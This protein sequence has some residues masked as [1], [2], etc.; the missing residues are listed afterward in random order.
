MS[1]SDPAPS[2]HVVA[3]SGAGIAD[4]GRQRLLVA[5]KWA[6]QISGTAYIPLPHAE[7]EAELLAV[8]N[9]LFD[10]I[11]A[12]PFDPEPAASIGARLVAMNCIGQPT[13]QRTMDVLG[14]ALLHQPELCGVRA[15][16]DKVVTLLGTF[17]AGYLESVREATLAQQE[18]LNRTMIAIGNDARTGLRAA[19]ARIGAIMD[20][21]PTGIAI[22]DQDGRIRC[23]N[24]V[25]GTLLGHSAGELT[26]LSL[27]DLFPP[28]DATFV[29]DA[30]DRLLDGSLRRLRQRRTMV[31]R[32]GDTVPVTLTGELVRDAGDQERLV[33]VVQDDSELRLLQNQLTR[34]SLH[35]VVTGLP[36]RQFF[37]TRLETALH[38]A[39]KH[40]ATLYHL[41]LDAFAMVTD[42]LGRHVGDQLL[43]AVAERLRTVV[44]G[45][46]AIVARLDSDEFAILV[47]NTATT[48]DA[49]TVVGRI[50]ERLAEPVHV[51]GRTVTVS[52]SMGV[53]HRPR[54]D[55]DAAELLRAS[56]LALR[57]AKRHGRR[58]WE[59]FDPDA[60]QADRHRFELATTMSSAWRAGEVRLEYRPQVSLATGAAVALEPVLRWVHPRFGV[61]PH[62][63]C[64]ELAEQT[65]LMV[66]LGDWLL[67]SACAAALELPLVV[68]LS[69]SQVADPD[70][71]DRVLRIDGLVPSRLSL[72]VPVRALH[73]DSTVPAENLRLLAD[74]GIGVALHGFDGAA[75]DLALLDE[76]PVSGVR[77][78]A[79]VVAA[80]AAS[81][82]SVLDR[83]LVD[84]VG[85]V[86][87]TGGAVAVDGVDS[88]AQV[89][90]WR[91]AGAD[92]A[93]GGQFTTW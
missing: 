33:V 9:Q 19:Q 83:M 4:P 71:V 27:F 87:E 61:V 10:L 42:G 24:G 81:S 32:A 82:R 92:V 40:G 15:L 65:G 1:A 44:A 8:V 53:V 14:K 34:Q 12:D 38:K 66:P 39:G 76:L 22:T 31:T 88:A 93:L 43:K 11:A 64:V 26:G 25:L 78:G 6:Y 56:D 70:V 3:D 69:G 58:Q 54:P 67:R 89:T 23:A 13:F 55:L 86:H 37:T 84:L 79:P 72:G 16:P 57:R 59:L 29:R 49:A 17:A 30:R 20:S 45:E 28:D 73:G 80:Q 77:I 18:S 48:P 63:R 21:A 35:D 75:L 74:A 36:N 41:D 2:V 50:N 90:W 52:A 60:G 68:E 62:G 7:V 51:D 46:Q 5:R 91:D 85:V 47:E